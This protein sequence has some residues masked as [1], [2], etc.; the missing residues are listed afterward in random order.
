MI[1][2]RDKEKETQQIQ[3]ALALINNARALPIG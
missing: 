2:K 3:T 1:T